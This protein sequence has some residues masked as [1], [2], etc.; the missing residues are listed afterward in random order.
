MKKFYLLTIIKA[1][2]TAG[3][4]DI[5]AALLV[6][7]VMMQKV[8]A[9]QLLQSIASGVLGKAAYDG[10]VSTALLGV[11]LHFVIAMIWAI[12]YYFIYPMLGKLAQQP[13]ISG[14]LYGAVVWLV[15]NLVVVPLS[16]IGFRPLTP[17]GVAIGMAILMVCIGLPIASIMHKRNRSR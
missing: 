4:C 2:L 16:Q 10:G 11:T 17:Q 9:T 13:V 14:L 1:G 5:L 7:S 6:Y 8:P 3:V 12:V 15:M